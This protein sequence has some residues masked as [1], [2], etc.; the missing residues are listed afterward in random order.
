[1]WK[2]PDGSRIQSFEPHSKGVGDVVAKS[3]RKLGFKSCGG[4]KKRQDKLNRLFP[5][6]KKKREIDAT[7]RGQGVEPERP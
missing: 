4:C 6:S 5:F 7:L 1:M 2:L 3:L